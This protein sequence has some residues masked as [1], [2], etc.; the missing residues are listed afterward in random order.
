MGSEKTTDLVKDAVGMVQDQM[1]GQTKDD[2][3]GGSKPSIATAVASGVDER[4]RARAMK[5]RGRS[6]RGMQ[7]Y[8]RCGAEGCLPVDVSGSP[9]RP[10]EGPGVRFNLQA[11]DAGCCRL[12]ARCAGPYSCVVPCLCYRP[13]RPD[14]NFSD[15]L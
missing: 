8:R 14:V 3:A 12:R 13:P 10:G 4:R 5:V 1:V 15:T 6:R 11:S 9:L 2:K 7:D